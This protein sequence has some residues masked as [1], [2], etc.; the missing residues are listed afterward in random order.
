MQKKLKELVIG[1]MEKI[2][3]FIPFWIL[4]MTWESVAQWMNFELFLGGWWI[5]HL[6]CFML[7]VSFVIYYN[8]NSTN[9]Q[10]TPFI[11]KTFFFLLF[12]NMVYGLFMSEGYQDTQ[13]MFAKLISWTLCTGW[14]YFQ[15]PDNVAKVT[16][17]WFKYAILL[18]FILMV[19][20]QG[21]AVGRFF[22]PCA[23]V[24]IFFPY[25]DKKWKLRIAVVV[26]IVLLMGALGARSSIIRFG[27]GILLAIAI[28]FQRVY[29]KVLTKILFILF[30]SLPVVLLYLGIT[31]QFNVF[32]F[33]EE[34]GL[35][36]VEVNSSF[37]NGDT[38]DLTGDT[39]TFLFVEEIQSA[40]KNDY[41]VYGRSLSRGY[42]SI[43]IDDVDWKHGR[44]ERWS[45]EVRFLNVFNYMGLIGVAIVALL[46]IIGA[47][48]AVFKSKSFAMQMIGL[49]V[50][51]RWLYG[52]IEDFDRFDLINLYIW[53]PI[54]MCYSEKF[55]KK[56]D[57]EFKMWAKNIFKNESVCKR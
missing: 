29:P 47:W 13:T 1:K 24:V 55:L 37:D 49:Y 21:E 11:F 25:L 46:Y 41:V 14:F 22:A 34:F 6:L 44:N 20:M 36:E 18:F 30:V 53:I 8:Y 31:D 10:K 57:A 40:I 42:D 43:V 7:P 33:Q 9:L 15:E 39:R 4:V 12:C 27:V 32:K 2:D 51:F 35:E 26:A 3:K 5:E 28:S 45:S 50:A 56:N 16:R 48:K 23:F 38:E 19:F 54:F 52:W 17:E